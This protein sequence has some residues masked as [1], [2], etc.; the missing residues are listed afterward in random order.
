MNNKASYTTLA[1]E[2][3][4]AKNALCRIISVESNI[5]PLRWTE[6]AGDIFIHNNFNKDVVC[7]TAIYPNSDGSSSSYYLYFGDRKYKDAA[8]EVEDSNLISITDAGGYKFKG[9][10]N[11]VNFVKKVIRRAYPSEEPIMMKWELRTPE[12]PTIRAVD[13]IFND[14]A[15]IIIWADGSKT[16]VKCRDGEEFDPEKGLAMA[17]SK[18]VLGNKYDY[19]DVF[20]KYIGKYRKKKFRDALKKA[21]EITPD[22]IIRSG[23]VY[24]KA[25]TQEA[26]NKAL[27]DIALNTAKNLRAE[28]KSLDEIAKIMGYDDPAVVRTILPN[29]W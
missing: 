13:V 26:Q 8:S 28:G 9:A 2:Y 20:K 4:I 27:R 17:I 15:T 1:N 6:T 7:R 19:Y 12:L 5:S 10:G 18:K 24:E 25:D 21:M 14:P 22:A 29:A 3:K 23:V 16:V 11:V